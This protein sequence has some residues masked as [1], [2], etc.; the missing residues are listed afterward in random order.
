VKHLLSKQNIN[1]LIDLATSRAIFAFD[2]DGTLAPLHPDRDRAMMRAQTQALFAHVCTRYRC[3]VISG[4]GRR[5]VER[6]MLRAPVHTIIGNHGLEDRE[7]VVSDAAQD[8]RVLKQLLVHL[9]GVDIEDKHHSLAVHGPSLAHVR[10]LV[11]RVNR[12]GRF[13]LIAGKRVLNIVSAT[14]PNK[15]DA[16]DQLM[17]RARVQRALFIGDD[18]TDE[19]VFARNS[20]SLLTVRVGYSAASKARY[21]VRN[22]FEVDDVL[23]L[24]AQIAMPL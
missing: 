20:T 16:L 17:K 7:R 1:A 13:R 5:D 23:D 9:R 6:R 24:L 3:V 8:M 18:V 12:R 22:Q 21:F 4:R 14:A 15:G 2:F 11:E 10:K 19:D